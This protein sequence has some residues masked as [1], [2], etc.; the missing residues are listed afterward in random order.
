MD[1][2]LLLEF[3]KTVFVIGWAIWLLSLVRDEPCSHEEE[4]L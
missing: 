2:W 3:A 4:E 1:I